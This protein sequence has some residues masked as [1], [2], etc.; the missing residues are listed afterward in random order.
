MAVRAQDVHARRLD[1]ERQRAEALDRVDDE[2]DAALAADR[3]DLGERQDEAVVERDP[4]D[5]DDAGPGVDEGGD[6]V[7]RDAAVPAL[8]DAAL[9]AALGAGPATGSAFDGNS[10][11]VVTTLSPAR[12]GKAER[13]EVEAPARVRHERDLGR[14]RR[15]IS[16]A[17]FSRA[18]STIRVPGAPVGGAAVADVLR[19]APSWRRR[20]AGAEARRP[21]G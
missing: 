16:R 5:G 17:A 19:R 8:R 4:G 13:D 15:W 21:H 10:R 3:A 20:R 18:V 2:E 11:S 9:D 14:P 7:R 12:P 1:V 6:V